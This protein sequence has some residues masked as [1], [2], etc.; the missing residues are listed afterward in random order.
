MCLQLLYDIAQEQHA[1]SIQSSIDWGC[2]TGILSLAIG[3]WFPGARLQALDIEP[4]AL[5]TTKANLDSNMIS[6]EVM[7]TL[8]ANSHANLIVANLVTQTLRE[9]AVRV[10][11]TLAPEG[12]LVVSGFLTEQATSIETYFHELGLSCITGIDQLE[13]SAKVFIKR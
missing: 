2:G 1:E 5:A 11:N 13:W 10:V 6:G 9:E 7:L 12:R 8:P 3:K 4:E